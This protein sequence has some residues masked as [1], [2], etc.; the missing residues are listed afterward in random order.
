MSRCKENDLNTAIET[1]GYGDEDKLRQI[2]RYT[3]HT[4]FD[5]KV[6]DEEKHIAFTG[7]SNKTI[8]ENA[9]IAAQESREMKVCVPVVPGC[10]DGDGELEQIA[11]FVNRELGDISGVLLHPY[12][13]AGVS[14]YQRLS[15]YY[16][17]KDIVAPHRR[18]NEKTR[19]CI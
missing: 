13:L 1:C 5:I 10:N 16:R 14:K 2:L 11:Q 9:K 19:R 12:N 8:L 15:R 17:M 7:V 3:D 18:R 6:M 4:M